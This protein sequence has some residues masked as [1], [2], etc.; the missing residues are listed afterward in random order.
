M[1]AK[2]QNQFQQYLIQQLNANTASQE[3]SVTS[4]DQTK[5]QE[6]SVY[7]DMWNRRYNDLFIFW[8]RHGHSSVPQ[9]Y[10]PNPPLGKWVQN[11]R[12]FLRARHNGE[13]TTLTTKRV[14]ALERLNFE[15]DP[16]KRIINSWLDR[17]NELVH[18]KEIHGHCDVPQK[19]AQNK[20]LGRW[21]HKQRHNL[22]RELEEEHITSLCKERICLLT[23][24]GFNWAL[25]RELNDSTKER[26]MRLSCD[27]V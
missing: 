18:Y 8:M 10:E 27:E 15:V 9:Q 21:V 13:Q 19:Y 3:D 11:Q 1:A 24:I 22:L 5:D 7:D 2:N 23:K 14:Q 6:S 17:W 4:Q 12:A 26:L 20:A 16:K 25:R